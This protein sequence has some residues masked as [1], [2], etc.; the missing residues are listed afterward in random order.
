MRLTSSPGGG[1]PRVSVSRCA[2]PVSAAW[3]G[4]RVHIGSGRAPARAVAAYNPATGK[5]T[6]L[7]S[8]TGTLTVTVN[9]VTRTITLTVG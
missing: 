2:H 8:G 7:R 6:G 1:H 3:A 5:V 4:E 9:G